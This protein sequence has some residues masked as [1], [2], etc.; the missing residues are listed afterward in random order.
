MTDTNCNC[1]NGTLV[2][3]TTPAPEIQ[4]EAPATPILPVNTSDRGP[5]GKDAKINGV[6]TL[7]L[8][9]EHGI[10]LNQ[11]GET[12]T[13]SGELLEQADE[14][15]QEQID[16]KVESVSGTGVISTTRTGNDIE[17]KSTT[18]IHEQ[19]EASSEWHIQ[20]NLNKHPSVTVV[21]SAGNQV[22]CGV[23]YN[24]TNNLTLS[25]NGAFKGFAY[26]N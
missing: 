19:A 8:T 18:Y 15:L 4:V 5:A 2:V 12:A 24:D 11:E 17:I 14:H 23:E 3:E 22:F 16:G 6:N 7:T 25:M 26:L 13:L 20:H 1:G 10:S 21:D 9:A